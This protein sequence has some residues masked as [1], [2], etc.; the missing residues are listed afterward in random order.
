MVSNGVSWNRAMKAG[1]KGRVGG[2]PILICGENTCALGCFIFNFF[3]SSH[4]RI[5]TGF[6][7]FHLFDG[8][9]CQSFNFKTDFMPR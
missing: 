1:R 4:V 9:W 7:L 8:L 2:E 3:F 5:P 6:P